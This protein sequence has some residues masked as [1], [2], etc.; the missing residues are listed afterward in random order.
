MIRFIYIYINMRDVHVF[1]SWW[2]W[3]L[4]LNFG[5]AIPSVTISWYRIHDAMLP[6]LLLATFHKVFWLM[7]WVALMELLCVYVWWTFI[8][9]ISANLLRASRSHFVLVVWTCFKHLSICMSWFWLHYQPFYFRGVET[10]LQTYHLPIAP[11]V[12]F[13]SPANLDLL[14]MNSTQM[15]LKSFQPLRFPPPTTTSHQC[16]WWSCFQLWQW[17][18]RDRFNTFCKSNQLAWP[19]GQRAG[20]W[21]Y[22]CCFH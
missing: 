18:W 1:C 14:K 20:P 8:S 6:W 5:M 19:A 16:V 7:R 11:G 3:M 4:K 21:V 9:L 10:K 12:S 22:P 2:P 13:V 17:K 15:A